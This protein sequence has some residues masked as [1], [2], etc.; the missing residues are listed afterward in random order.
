MLLFKKTIITSALAI[1]FISSA[2]AQTSVQVSTPVTNQ[3]NNAANAA[4]GSGGNVSG[5]GNATQNATVN[6][7]GSQV[8]TS[9]SISGVTGSGNST[10]ASQVQSS[11]A[12]NPS[13]TNANTFAPTVQ[14]GSATGANIGD[15]KIN[16][17]VVGP[18]NA[19]NST[20]T[21]AGANANNGNVT[22]GNQAL[23]QNLNGGSAQQNVGGATS[24]NAN[25]M[26]G[27][28]STTGGSANTNSGPASTTAG[29]ATSTSGPASTN[30]GAAT[31][32]GGSANGSTLTTGPSTSAGGNSSAAGGNGSSTTTING[33]TY[34][35]SY[36]VAGAYV[37]L[38]P[39]VMSS[40]AML[41]TTTS[42][43]PDFDTEVV[44]SVQATTNVLFG[45]WTS[46]RGNGK[47]HAVK[48][49]GKE[50]TYT[51]WATVGEEDGPAGS[52]RLIQERKVRGYQA[53]I[54]AYLAGSS[55]GS[56]VNVNGQS[57]AVG[58]AGSGGIQ[59]YGNH[60]FKFPCEQT[61]TRQLRKVLRDVS[62]TPLAA[63]PLAPVTTTAFVP[64]KANPSAKKIITKSKIP[65][66]KAK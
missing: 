50:M 11:I 35:T 16:G 65:C 19:G 13:N 37:G 10:S 46:T 20:A 64:Q 45:L 51:E 49:S 23:N 14:A 26:S 15:V 36:P 44:D 7:S 21:N 60:I 2:N 31:T 29:N 39:Q 53:Q 24:G 62:V 22:G 47:V 59:T 56:G 27:A 1:A 12:V 3:N 9:H 5:S 52:S 30:S 6:Q 43:G 57:A 8:G 4:G 66:K 48:P 41:V 18:A 25:T 33:D 17:P 38:P 61:Q 28:A 42:C 55:A 32:N 54:H 34:R 40:G 63:L 58:L